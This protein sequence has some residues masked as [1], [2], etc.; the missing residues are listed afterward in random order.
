M[1][2]ALP[3]SASEATCTRSF[4]EGYRSTIMVTARLWGGQTSDPQVLV[5]QVP[6][7]PWFPFCKQQIASFG[8]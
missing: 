8:F 7:K 5:P 6:G 3:K 2:V 4:L 1:V